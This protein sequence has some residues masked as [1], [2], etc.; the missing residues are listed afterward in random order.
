MSEPTVE[1]RDAQLAYDGRVIWSGLDFA[2]APGEFITVLGPNGSG[3]SSLIKA[4]LG[5]HP[6][7]GGSVLVAGS[8]PRRGSDHIGY[9]PQQ[10]GFGRDVP[11][12]ARDLVQLGVDGNRWGLP[13]PGRNARVDTLLAD[14]NATEFADMPVGRLSGGEQQRLR[15]AQALAT[16]PAVLLLDE[17][18]LSLD[19]PSQGRVVDLLDR[20]RRERGTSVIF[21]THEI[22]PVLSVT[23][24]V[25]YLAHGRSRFGPPEEVMTSASLSELYDAPIEVIAHRG[26][27]VVLGVEAER[28]ASAHH[29]NEDNA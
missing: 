23:D 1:F 5:L 25:L 27:L 12:R 15:M 3:K 19:L 29:S 14:V 7:S 10:K 13:R 9:V 26:S 4:I 17:P 6:L 28:Q 8:A 21:I 2:V 11:L 22:N 18:L 24:H 20:R 16:D